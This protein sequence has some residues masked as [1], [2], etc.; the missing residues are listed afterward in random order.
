MKIVVATLELDA[1]VSDE[2]EPAGTEDV[3]PRFI[4]DEILDVKE[5][6]VRAS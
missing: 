1:A 6:N 4:R 5:G 2:C 3:Y